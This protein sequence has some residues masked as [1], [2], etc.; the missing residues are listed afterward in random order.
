MLRESISGVVSEGQVDDGRGDADGADATVHRPRSGSPRTDGKREAD[1]LSTRYYG[2]KKRQLAWLREEFVRVE[3]ETVL[4]AFGGTG[5]VSHLWRTLGWAVTYNDVFSFNTISATAIFSNSTRLYP[6][7]AVR[8][9]LA[10]VKP[11]HGFISQTF[12]GLYFLRA[13]NEWIDGLLGKLDEQDELF[14]SLLLHCLFQACLQKRPFNLFHRANLHLRLF[15]GAVK[16]GNRTTWER[17]FPELM[18]AAYREVARVQAST[19]HLPIQVTCAQPAEAITGDFDVVY[20]DPPYLHQARKTDSY[21]QRYHF[22]E[23]LARYKDWP[24]LVDRQSPLRQIREGVVPEWASKVD[25][26]QNL[27]GLIERYRKSQ[28]ILSY[29]S[30]E[31]PSEADLIEIFRRNFDHV[32]VSRRCF[33]RALSKK[34][35]V[36]ILISG[37]S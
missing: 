1:F 10:D 33:S 7:G 24:S 5:A 22:L 12:E 31:F 28:V 26:R 14:R 36:E 2:S 21:L 4:D 32:R 6:E 11:D 17:P 23:G 29:V 18:I 19:M 13:E 37:R 15:D 9:F 8:E 16:F 20:I 35:F 25:F 34:R 27:V 30:G 3:G